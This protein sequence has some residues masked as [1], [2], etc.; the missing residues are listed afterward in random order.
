MT[1]SIAKVSSFFQA[2]LS[3]QETVSQQAQEYAR[4]RKVGPVGV[5]AVDGMAKKCPALKRIVIGDV[6]S[7]R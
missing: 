4:F 3:T 7:E 1:L 2:E 6:V 5:G